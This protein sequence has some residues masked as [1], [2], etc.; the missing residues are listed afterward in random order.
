[1]QGIHSVRLVLLDRVLEN[2]WIT[3]ED[4]TISA[5][6]QRERPAGVEWL[7]GGQ[8]YVSPGLIDLH[9]HGGNGADALD[10]TPEALLRKVGEILA[11][12]RKSA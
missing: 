4:G 5:L 12:L 10:G 7:D 6:G 11:E 1:M 3:M 9:V 8:L 2:A